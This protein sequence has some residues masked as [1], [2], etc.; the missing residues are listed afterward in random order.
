L[1]WGEGEN[2]GYGRLIRRGATLDS[3]LKGTSTSGEEKQDKPPERQGGSI[4]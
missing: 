2:I 1:F 4:T 3:Y